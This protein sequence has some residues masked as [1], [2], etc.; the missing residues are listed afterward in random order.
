MKYIISLFITLILSLLSFAQ[1][2]E[3]IQPINLSQTV[4]QWRADLRYFAEELPKRHKNAFHFMTREQFENAVKQFD[5]E[6]PGLTSEQIYVRFIKLISMVGDGHTS[7]E[8]RG[9]LSLGIYPVRY[10]IFQDGLFVQSAAA[11]NAEIVGGKVVK[12]AN[13]PVE[14]VLQ[15]V[16]EISWGDNLNEQSLKVEMSFLLSCPKILQGLKINESD[17]KV[18][19]TVEKNGQQKTMEVKAVA[20]FMNFMRKAKRVY[21]Y[22][23]SSNPLPLYLKN[24]NENYWFDYVKESK[25]L[26]VQFNSV[27]N[28][29]DESISAFFKKVFDFAE[30]NPVEKFVLDVR[31]NTGG[32]NQ[33]NKPVVIGL[34]KAKFNERGKF[35]VVIGRRTFSAAQN[36]VN[37][38]EKYTNAIF[39][40]EPTGSS[41][42]LYG[43]AIIIT[44][45]NSK[46]A[47]RVATLWHQIDARDTRIYTAPEI[48]TPLTSK[49][50]QNNID[51]ALQG[52]ANYVPGSTFKDL[53]AE[54]SKNADISIFIKKYREFKL[55]P[56]NQFINT[57]TEINA[58]GYRLVRAKRIKDAIE[59]FKLNVEAYPNSANVYDSL[60]ESYLLD[61][62]KT[63]A[64]KNYEK[65]V[66]L[67]PNFASSLDALRRLKG[68]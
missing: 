35:F 24:P 30:R 46:I 36:L 1:H 67:N 44:L 22:E 17:E 38:I 41:P 64:V 49:D 20:D 39:V 50:F 53:A 18:S 10:E 58:L 7:I 40:G 16:K 63:E 19:V 4:E 47:F 6:I 2:G 43:D 60:A 5:S 9:L 37:E 33:L 59:V 29:S 42:N 34:I 55:N 14:D 31:G 3:N 32:N 21:A 52:I 11:E 56:Q 23:N 45:P 15:K 57:E 54:A 62:N 65:A 48:F 26:Y 51:P 28:K 25:I 66:L 61:G 13:L 27:E 8:E 68:N 12:I